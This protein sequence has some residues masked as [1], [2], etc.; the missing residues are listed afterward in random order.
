MSE[1]VTLP[2]Q[3]FMA[4]LAAS[5]P[6]GILLL[7]DGSGGFELGGVEY[8][9]EPPSERERTTLHATHGELMAQASAVISA[10]AVRR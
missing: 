9:C 2:W 8:L 1:P 10:A 5:D 6:K 3:E 7:E 4:K